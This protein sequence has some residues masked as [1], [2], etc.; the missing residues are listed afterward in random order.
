MS[1]SGSVSIP[2]HLF[3]SIYHV[4]QCFI[5][6]STLTEGIIGKFD[7]IKQALAIFD[8]EDELTNQ[9]REQYLI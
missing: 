1:K 5:P 7:R 3:I 2:T 4:V 6:I 9:I 8:Y